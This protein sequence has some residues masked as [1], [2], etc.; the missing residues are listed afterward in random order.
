[1]H[2]RQHWEH[3]YATKPVD[4]VSWFQPHAASSLRLIED[5]GVAKSAPIVD[6]GGGASV[7]V[8]DLL[9]HGYSN[10]SVLDIS[11]KALARSRDRLAE[12]AAEVRWIESDFLEAA[13][14][15]Q[16]CDIWHDRAAFHFLT[17][18]ED[19]NAYRRAALRAIRPGGY[20]IIA[21]FAADG[22]ERCSGLPVVRYDASAL[23]AELGDGFALVHHESQLHRT[24]SGTVQRFTLASFRKIPQ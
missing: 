8:D 20:L 24:P 17:S 19:R 2:A 3:V 1:M 23:Q 15:E 10:V 22:P 5:T 12:R 21:T 4:Q 16:S 7:L 11:G 18:A 13:L 9:A 14:P 6:I